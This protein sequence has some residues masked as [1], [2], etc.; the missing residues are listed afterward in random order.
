MN[1]ALTPQFRRMFR[2]L[3]PALRE[4]ALEKIALFKTDPNHSQ[5]RSHK[6]QG[7]LKGRYSFSVNY[8]TR[9]VYCFLSDSE[10]AFLTIGNHSVYN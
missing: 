1:I 7:K 8:K 2:K 10:V 9:I 4:E 5:L 6:L 3:E